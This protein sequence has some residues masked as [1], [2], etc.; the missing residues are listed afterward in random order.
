MKLDIL[1]PG[2]QLENLRTNATQKTKHEN[3]KVELS[4]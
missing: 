3:I 1:S 2:Q 4:I